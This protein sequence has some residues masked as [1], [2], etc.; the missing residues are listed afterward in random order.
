M[1]KTHKYASFITGDTVNIKKNA[2]KYIVTKFVMMQT[3]M[4]TNAKDA[5]P[6]LVSLV[7]AAN[8]IRK[9][10]NSFADTAKGTARFQPQ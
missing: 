9:N 10:A 8:S 5:T 2:K 7:F 4:K 6:I 3:A 1:L